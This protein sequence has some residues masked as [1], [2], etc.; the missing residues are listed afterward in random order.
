MVTPIAPS[1]LPSTRVSW[2]DSK[3]F[4]NTNLSIGESGA[5]N[6]TVYYCPSNNHEY[7][8]GNDVIPIKVRNLKKGSK[9]NYINKGSHCIGSK[10][11]IDFS[12]ST[13][14]NLPQGLFLVVL[15]LFSILTTFKWNINH[16]IFL[17]N[18]SALYLFSYNL[19]LTK[20][21]RNPSI[22]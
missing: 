22:L 20:L 18:F 13:R 6:G 2:D 17:Y 14:L 5:I 8:N 16:F 19:L 10:E 21:Y 7:C 11:S 9:L 3:I 4:A 1:Y 15:V 12:S